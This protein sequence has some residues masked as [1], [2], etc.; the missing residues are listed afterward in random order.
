MSEGFLAASWLGLKSDAA[1]RNLTNKSALA[2]SPAKL[3]R[4]DTLVE[5][6]STLS[7]RTQTLCGPLPLLPILGT[8]ARQLWFLTLSTFHSL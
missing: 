4:L 3:G 2:R 1:E 8:S 7:H 5:V 6:L